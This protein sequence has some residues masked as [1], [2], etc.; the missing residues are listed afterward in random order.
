MGLDIRTNKRENLPVYAAADGYVARIK[1]E[2][3]GFG[4]AIYINHPNGFTTLYAHLNNFNPKLEAFVKQKQY[5]IE[6]WAIFIEV[7]TNMF[8]VKQDEFLAYSG[9]TGGSQAP[10]LHFEIRTTSDDINVNPLLFGLPLKDNVKPRVTRLGI[11][12]RTKSTYEQSPRLLPLKFENNRYTTA[13]TVNFVNTPFI[14]TAISAFD[15]YTGSLNPNGIFE[16]SLSMDRQP[17]VSFRMNQISYNDTRNLNGH[18]DYKTK[19]LRGY[20]L[21]HLSELPGNP[22]SIYHKIHGNGVLDLSDGQVHEIL[23]S[24]CDT[25]NNESNIAF[26]VQ[27]V[28]SGV[29]T[30]P[31]SGKLFHP[32]QIDG[33]ESA[34]C[35]FFIGEN[36]LYDSVHIHYTQLPRKMEPALSDVHQIGFAY[37]P[38]HEPFLVRIKADE[39]IT[40]FQKSRTIMQWTS[41]SKKDVQKVE[42]Q[43]EWGTAR[44]RD[45]GSFQLLVDEE[46]PQIIP[47]GFVNGSNLSKS[48]R[49]AFTIKDD[50]SKFKNVRTELDGNWLRFTNDKGRTFIYRFDEKCARGTHQLKIHAE[51]EAGNITEQTFQFER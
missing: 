48:T 19:T 17:Q 14:S 10:H 31:D 24:L 33:F 7:P 47:I 2:P 11:Y 42:W 38:L 12:D 23:I 8:P 27:Y 25:Y 1:I 20:S 29:P 50:H 28:P 13:A 46:P 5:E 3:G 39:Q 26:K 22:N 32:L 51:D 44:F 36:C 35:E 34:H 21:Q 37:I 49:I 40:A 9:N 16:A 18:I 41:G 45:F 4:R 43:N 6:S 15:T 30:S